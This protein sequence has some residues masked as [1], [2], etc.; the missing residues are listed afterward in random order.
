MSV[1][2]IYEWLSQKYPEYQ[3]TKYKIRK[4]LK[5]DFERKCPRF[6]IGNRDRLAGIPLRYIIRPG[7]ESELRKSFGGPPRRR[8][9]CQFYG[10]LSQVIHCVL[11]KRGFDCHESF[12]THQREAHSHSASSSSTDKETRS[13]DHARVHIGRRRNEERELDCNANADRF[14]TVDKTVRDAQ[15]IEDTASCQIPDDNNSVDSISAEEQG[16]D[17]K[18]YF[19]HGMVTLKSSPHRR[20]PQDVKDKV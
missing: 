3:Y 7:T 4:V 20:S 2:E 9:I 17:E 19:I 12:V 8:Q 16:V 14:A 13:V 1:A 6:V 5:H 11:C 18:Y 10:G 15:I